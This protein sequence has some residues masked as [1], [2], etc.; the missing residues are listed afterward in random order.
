MKTALTFG[1]LALTAAALG[2]AGTALADAAPDAASTPAAD[3]AA[4]DWARYG[5]AVDPNT[6]IVGHPA[7]PRWVVAHANHEHPA[8]VQARLAAQ[9]AIDPN[10][11]IV[12]PPA[13]VKWLATSDAPGD[14][15]ASR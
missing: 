2:I 4:S 5:R 8:V 12:Q 14:V 11:F 1:R 3:K 15:V 6:F 13:S 10:T 9:Q 7:S